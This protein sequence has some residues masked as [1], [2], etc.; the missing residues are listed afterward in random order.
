M[1]LADVEDL[2]RLSPNN[3]SVFGEIHLPHL[4][5]ANFGGARAGGA[6]P[7]LQERRENERS[8]HKWRIG[9]LTGMT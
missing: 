8:V 2:I 3:A 7:P 4:G 5:K 6:S 9:C 1:R